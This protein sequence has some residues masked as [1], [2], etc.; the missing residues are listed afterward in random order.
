MSPTDLHAMLPTAFREQVQRAIEEAFNGDEPTSLT[1]LD[2]GLSKATICLPGRRV[3]ARGR[4]E[5]DLCGCEYGDQHQR[6]YRAAVGDADS[7][8]ACE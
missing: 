3:T 2:G 1:R 6:V 4:A 7:G 5:T 8:G